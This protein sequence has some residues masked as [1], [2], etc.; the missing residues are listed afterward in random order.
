LDWIQSNELAEVPNPYPYPPCHLYTNFLKSSRPKSSL[1][2]TP[3][4][5]LP[6]KDVQKQTDGR[7]DEQ[8]A[9]VNTGNTYV[10]RLK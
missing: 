7:T 9:G 6:G 5:A 8:A 4:V 1:T 3:D 2:S 10:I